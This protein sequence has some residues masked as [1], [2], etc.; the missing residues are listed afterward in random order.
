[1]ARLRASQLRR[2]S[3]ALLALYEETDSSQPL[4]AITNLSDSLLSVTG[5]TVDAVNLATGKVEHRSGRRLEHIPHL[6]EAIT[7]YCHQNPLVAYALEGRFAPALRISDFKT[8]REIRVTGFYHEIVRHFSGWRDQAAMPIR[9][10][11]TSLGFTFNH[12]RKISDE[13]LLML[14]LFQPHAERLLRRWTQYWRSR[15]KRH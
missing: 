6:D 1:M 15:R 14:E 5:I 8:F 11:H 4:E 10:P 3:R 12:D 7:H 13:E 2:L 9:L